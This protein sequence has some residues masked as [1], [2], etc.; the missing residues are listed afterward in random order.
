M[1]KFFEELLTYD[2]ILK[3]YPIYGT[4]RKYLIFI[5][6]GGTGLLIAE[7]ITTLLTESFNMWYL[8]SYTIGTAVSII[9]TF[10]Y[11]RYITFRKS[12]E[13]RKRF[14]KFVFVVTVIA[15]LN[16]VLVYFFTEAAAAFLGIE[17]SKLLYWSTIFIITLVLS[18]INFAINKLWVFK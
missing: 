12:T 4:L 13:I 9:F 10:I 3:E 5:A 11:H 14:I 1:N 8:I 2:R 17:I 16:V 7:A 6:G 15:T 18:T